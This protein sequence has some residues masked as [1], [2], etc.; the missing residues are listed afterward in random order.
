MNHMNE[1]Q[2]EILATF[3]TTIRPDW[4]SRKIIAALEK[5]APTTEVT[6]LALALLHAANE[7]ANKQPSIIEYVGPHWDKAAGVVPPPPKPAQNFPVK[8]Q[9]GIDTSPMCPNHPE[10]HHWEC[11]TCNRPAPRPA[12]FH[13]LVADAAEKERLRRQ[14]EW[15]T[16]NEN[17]PGELQGA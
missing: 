17:V 3:T 11:R 15:A 1:E 4:D 14:A 16:G 7:P 12:N 13:Q 9:D 5:M 8:R 6:Q 2:A 10:K